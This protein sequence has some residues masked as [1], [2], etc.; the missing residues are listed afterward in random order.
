MFEHANATTM[1]AVKDLGRAR[2]FYEGVLGLTPSGPEYP[3][4][5]LY[6]A[7][8]AR[9]AAYVSR[10]AGTNRATALSREVAPP[11]TPRGPL[12]Q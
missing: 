5:Q 7:G 9:L 2:D 10:H 1:L 12:E 4:V 3:G 6:Q 8:D 11:A